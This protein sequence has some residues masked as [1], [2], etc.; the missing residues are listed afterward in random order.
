MKKVLVG[1]LILFSFVSVN[2]SSNSSVKNIKI[3]NIKVEIKENVGYNDELKINY[4]INPRDAKNLNLV[5]SVLGIKKGVTAT[6]TNGNKTTESDGTI[7]L[8]L[9]NTLSSDVTLTLVGSQNG[10][11]ISSTKFVVEN[12]EKTVE[13]VTKE[14]NDIINNLSEDIDK[15]NYEETKENIEKAEELLENNSEAKENIKQDALD[16]LNEVKT[17]V[18]SYKANNK[19]VTVGVSIGLAAIFSGLLYW[20]FK[21]EEK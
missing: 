20:I 16:K 13:R 21:K 14:V 3:E 2:A 5:W 10:K 18:E 17:N 9:D 1:L 7:V 15:D 4:S 12:K 19:A 6:F 11:T 8:K